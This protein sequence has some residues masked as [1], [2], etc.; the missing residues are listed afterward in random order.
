MKTMPEP[1]VGRMLNKVPVQLPADI[2]H[3][4]MPSFSMSYVLL[5]GILKDVRDFETGSEELKGMDQIYRQLS[6]FSSLAVK[7]HWYVDVTLNEF[8]VNHHSRRGSKEGRS[9]E[10]IHKFLEA[11]LA[12]NGK[13]LNSFG[14]MFDHPLVNNLS[15]VDMINDLTRMRNVI[16]HYEGHRY[17]DR[18]VPQA[19]SDFIGKYDIKPPKDQMLFGP[20]GV[21]GTKAF[22]DFIKETLLV[23]TNSILSEFKFYKR[24]NSLSEIMERNCLLFLSHNLDY[25]PGDEAIRLLKDAGYF[26][27]ANGDTLHMVES[28][29]GYVFIVESRGLRSA[30]RLEPSKMSLKELTRND[31]SEI[32]FHDGDAVYVLNPENELLPVRDCFALSA[33]RRNVR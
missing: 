5:F 24:C 11:S 20:L 2:P 14:K 27:S 21:I 4:P 13:K 25:V 16:Y 17:E 32:D 33:F 31:A 19:I 7:A 30:F 23:F 8:A 10:E 15:L 29:E 22:V 26:S 28:D 9:A 3:L 6:E 1:P 12:E 18:D